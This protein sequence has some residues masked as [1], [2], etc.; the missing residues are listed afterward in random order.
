MVNKPL[1][2][3]DINIFI[4]KELQKRSFF[5]LKEFRIA[6]AELDIVYLDPDTLL[7]TNIEIK[8]DNWRKLYFQALRGKLY[9]HFSVAV[10][11]LASKKNIP[12]ELFSEEGIGIIFYEQRKKKIELFVEL[13]PKLSDSINRNLKKIIYKKI[14][15]NYGNQTYA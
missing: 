4:C 11:P 12:L 15:N 13:L 8:R 3:K 14:Y 5:V 6:P 1:L 9:C 10:M 2:E 7:L